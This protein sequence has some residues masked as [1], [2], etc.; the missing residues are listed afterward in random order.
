MSEKCEQLLIGAI[1][2]GEIE[3]FLSSEGVCVLE[4]LL[5]KPVSSKGVSLLNC[6]RHRYL[7]MGM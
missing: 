2:L 7:L 3:K 4:K 6:R 5:D 1:F